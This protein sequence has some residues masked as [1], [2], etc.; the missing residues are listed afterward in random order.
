[1]IYFNIIGD[2]ENATEHSYNF[3]ISTIIDVIVEIH[4]LLP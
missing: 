4:G 1:M 3:M 2:I